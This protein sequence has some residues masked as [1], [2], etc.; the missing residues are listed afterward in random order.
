MTHSNLGTKIGG[1]LLMGQAKTKEN[2][3]KHGGGS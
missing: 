2:P 1:E 3:L